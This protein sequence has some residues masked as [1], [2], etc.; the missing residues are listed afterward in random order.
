[1]HKTVTIP[2][3]QSSGTVPLNDPFKTSVPAKYGQTTF[4]R[5]TWAILNLCMNL[6]ML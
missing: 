1:M 4:Q 6:P 5:F 2:P 3:P